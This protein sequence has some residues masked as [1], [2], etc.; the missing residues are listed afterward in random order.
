MVIYYPGALYQ[1]TPLDTTLTGATYTSTTSSATVTLS[2]GA[3]TDAVS[4]TDSTFSIREIKN[5]GTVTFS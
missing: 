5:S 1:I 4:Y 3:E 2:G